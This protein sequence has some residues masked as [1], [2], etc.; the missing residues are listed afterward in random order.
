MPNFPDTF[1]TRKRSCTSGFSIYMTVPLSSHSKIM[2]RKTFWVLTH[3]NPVIRTRA[4]VYQRVTLCLCLKVWCYVIFDWAPILF[5]QWNNITVTTSSIQNMLLENL[6]FFVWSV[7]R[8]LNTMKTLKC[9]ASN[10][11]GDIRGVIWTPV[12]HLS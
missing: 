12:Q 8:L 11:S 7:Y 3:C 2:Q 6:S 5:S 10:L 9:F 4:R 1:E